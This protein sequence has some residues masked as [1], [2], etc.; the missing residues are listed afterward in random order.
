MG[1]PVQAVSVYC[2]VMKMKLWSCVVRKN[3]YICSVK[4]DQVQKY[5]FF[6][7]HITTCTTKQ[8]ERALWRSSRSLR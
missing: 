8:A 4:T 5:L 3:V 6:A 2:S 1:F 7:S